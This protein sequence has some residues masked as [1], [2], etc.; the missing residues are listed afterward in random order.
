MYLG[1]AIN[2]NQIN[3]CKSNSLYKCKK[4]SHISFF[5]QKESNRLQLDHIHYNFKTVK[6][7]QV[8][9]MFNK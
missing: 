4:S 1:I 3:I 9:N 8:S 7:E 2:K 6:S 5:K